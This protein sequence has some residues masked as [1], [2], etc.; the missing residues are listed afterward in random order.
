MSDVLNALVQ[1]DVRH[2]ERLKGLEKRED[3]NRLMMAHMHKIS[4][5][6]ESLTQRVKENSDIIKEHVAQQAVQNDLLRAYV[7]DTFKELRSETEK[8][9]KSLGERIGQLHSEIDER[10]RIQGERIGSILKEPGEKAK[11]GWETVK[12]AAITAVV[13]VVITAIAMYFIYV[14]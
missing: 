9:L 12:T 13:S 7:D 3:E 1:N 11:K 4:A 5:N 8:R 6:I 10:F 14:G 2:D